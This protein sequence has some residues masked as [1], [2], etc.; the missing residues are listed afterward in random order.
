[1]KL[2]VIGD[3]SRINSG[4]GVAKGLDLGALGMRLEGIP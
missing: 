2:G 3:G 1:M 4:T